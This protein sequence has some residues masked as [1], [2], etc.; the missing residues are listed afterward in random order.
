MSD[1][2]AKLA[3]RLA[4]VWRSSRP[5]ILERVATLRATWVS[6]REN[7]ENVEARA[8]GREAAHK[9]AGVLGVF[10]LAQGSDL[11]SAMEERLETEELFGAEDLATM[12]GQ[13]R[14]LEA[15]IASRPE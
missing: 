14:E 7:P 13:I 6:L 12:G 11:A 8:R 10:G 15:L 9:L 2:A 1:A 5:S 3:A 4:E